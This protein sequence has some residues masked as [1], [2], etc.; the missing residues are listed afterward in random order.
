M[1]DDALFRKAVAASVVRFFDF[2][3]NEGYVVPNTDQSTSPQSRD[4]VI[5]IFYRILCCV[6]R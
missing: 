6:G 5:Y 3:A 1:K 2:K 4:S